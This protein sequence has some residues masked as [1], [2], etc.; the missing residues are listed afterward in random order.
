MPRFAR[1][2]RNVG[3][4]PTFLCR[5]RAEVARALAQIREHL[6]ISQLDL[7]HIAGFAS[8]YTGKLECRDVPN[9]HSRHGSGRNAMQ[10]TLDYWLGALKVGL[11]VVP[12]AGEHDIAQARLPND[13]APRMT[14]KRAEKIRALHREGRSRNTLWRMFQ[15]TPQQI[16]DILAGRSHMPMAQLTGL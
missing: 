12:L 14:V 6:G 4:P 15:T 8:G 1:K 9:G 11:I 10:P 3:P 13:A 2:P 7:D 16:D 5:N